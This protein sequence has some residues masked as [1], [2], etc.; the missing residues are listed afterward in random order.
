M[1]LLY[2]ILIV[3]VIVIIGVLLIWHYK[4]NVYVINIHDGE[5][6]YVNRPHGGNIKL[7]NAE[8]VL[9]CSFI[10]VKD[11]LTTA[12]MNSTDDLCTLDAAS[13]GLKPGG[14][15][16]FS[17]KCGKSDKNRHH[18]DDRHHHWDDS[19]HHDD[20]RHH[21]KSNMNGRP[22]GNIPG[23]TGTSSY[24][25]GSDDA[26][27]G[28]N[29]ENFTQRPETLKKDFSK[30]EKEIVKRLENS[31]LTERM[32][33]ALDDNS[34]DMIA[35]IVKRATTV[36]MFAPGCLHAPSGYDT[37]FVTDNQCDEFMINVGMNSNIY[38]PGNSI[39]GIRYGLG[40]KRID[41]RFQP[42][43]ST[44]ENGDYSPSQGTHAG[45]STMGGYIPS[46]FQTSGSWHSTPYGFTNADNGVVQ[47]MVTNEAFLQF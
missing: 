21:H 10:K 35:N 17:Y 45:G 37:D 29:Q 16:S 26:N 3:L 47:Q 43:Y 19:H 42:G 38:T 15:F 13:M 41:P 36:E 1:K 18:S 12:I 2:A 24:Q 46:N 34:A 5:S 14:A 30:V 4:D 20:D 9:G 11:K 6:V 33:K 23:P 31:W 32:D 25:Y 22:D 8:Y 28:S 40:S 44:C 7:I 39:T 27:V